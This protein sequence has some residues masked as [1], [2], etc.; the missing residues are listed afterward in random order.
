[1]ARIFN[2]ITQTVGNTPLVRL[3]R[4]VEGAYAAVLVKVES[5]NPV[6]SIK[7][8]VGIALVE[9]ARQ[10]GVLKPGSVI[11]EPTSGN[12]GIALACAAAAKGYRLILTM[13]DTMSIER[14][15]LLAAFGAEIVLT[16]G[17]EGMN[18]AIKTAES[19]AGSIPNAVMMR[20]F[21][22]PANPRIHRDTTGPEIWKDSGGR[23]DFLVAGVGTGGTITG[24]GSMLK[25]KKKS[26]KVIA[27]EP[28][29]CPVLSGGKSGPHH[30]QGIGAG[31]IPK[32]LDRS[33]IDEVIRVTDGD[34]A[35]T[36]RRLAESEG[37]LAGI[38]GGAALWA[39]LQVAGR[40]ENKGKTVVVILPD[41]G[42]R[43]L[44]T[45]LF[46]D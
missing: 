4:I 44:S 18:G 40:I 15:Q 1:M 5:F 26:L 31:F 19:L 30:I 41:S 37:I 11:I 8:R 46:K 3:N 23:I 21:E 6:S 10:R 13:P 16:P 22:N 33:I 28:D 38:S 35:E 7:D 43:Y 14:R 32:A 17:G 39:G 29:A 45:G 25:K 27:V 34:A 9:D 24:A 42:E 12:T 2:D 36:S 20:Q